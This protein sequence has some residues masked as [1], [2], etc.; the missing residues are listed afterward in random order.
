VGA[1][2]FSYA[3][4]GAIAVVAD[5]DLADRA[6]SGAARISS[7][8]LDSASHWTSARAEEAQS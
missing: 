4:F 8:L 2:R 1:L 5:T 7:E 3:Q 6:L